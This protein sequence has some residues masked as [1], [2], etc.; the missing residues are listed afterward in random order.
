MRR[1]ACRAFLQ[2]QA[3][4]PPL[5]WGL[6]IIRNFRLLRIHLHLYLQQ[7]LFYLLSEAAR[8]AISQVCTFAWFV[9]DPEDTAYHDMTDSVLQSLSHVSPHY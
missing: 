7:L 5:V 1:A 6:L 8:R 4:T 9:Q 3:G 2:Y